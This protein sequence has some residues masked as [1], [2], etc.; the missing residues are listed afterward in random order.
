MH[1]LDI[2]DDYKNNISKIISYIKDFYW[3]TIGWRIEY[4]YTSVKNLIRWSPI[5]W[6]DR[7]WDD[8]F[9]WEVLKF[10]LK[11]QSKYIGDRDTYTSSKYG[12]QRMMLCVKLIDKIQEEYYS[13]EYMDYHEYNWLNIDDKPDY[14]KLEI[15]DISEKYDE[16]F[17]QHKAAVRKVL[18]NEKYQ[19]FKLIEDDYKKRLAMNLGHYNEKRAQ[20]ILFKLLNR[21]IRGWY[22]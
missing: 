13:M 12:A 19:I 5:I 14:K 10:K 18:A 4:F 20:D 11:N 1:P 8:Y 3:K 6:K 9:I 21:D 16:Y 17:N 22:G 15:V 7:D 2:D